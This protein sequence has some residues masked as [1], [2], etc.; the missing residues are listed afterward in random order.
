LIEN[1]TSHEASTIL[2]Q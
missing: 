1:L 2:N